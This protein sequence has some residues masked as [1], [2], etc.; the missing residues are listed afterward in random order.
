MTNMKKA[1]DLS[2]GGNP[3]SESALVS[4][5]FLL[6]ENRLLREALWRILSKKEDIQVVGAGSFG[7]EAVAQIISTK[8]NVVV[9]DS[10]SV[11]LAENGAINKL[12]QQNPAIRIVMVGMEAEESIF[13]RA[14][15][16]GALGYALK[17]ASPLQVS[18]TIRSVAP[19]RA[20][21]PGILS[22][23]RCNW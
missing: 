12:H 4:T 16:S 2:Q 8:A 17:D 3:I 1:A 20:T 15:Q 22:M 6:A 21:G 11:A 18:R 5:V 7:P 19:G 9:L 23:A 14:V 13:L 10:I